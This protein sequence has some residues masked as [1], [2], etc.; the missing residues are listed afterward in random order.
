MTNELTH[1]ST[2]SMP[3]FCISEFTKHCWEND[4]CHAGLCKAQW[5]NTEIKGQH[6]RKDSC[7]EKQVASSQPGVRGST[8]NTA[9]ATALAVW[10]VSAVFTAPDGGLSQKSGNQG[11]ILG[12]GTSACIRKKL[13]ATTSKVELL[14]KLRRISAMAWLWSRW[15]AVTDLGKMS[16]RKTNG[17]VWVGR[18][19]VE[20][21]SG[22]K[23][24]LGKCRSAKFFT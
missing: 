22:V 1:P 23:N 21:T 8:V 18:T 24:P 12:R 7:K 14:L 2:T 4:D 15:H 11:K 20:E 3:A 17:N 6:W 9:E 5:I 19:S 13:T 16:T 10:R